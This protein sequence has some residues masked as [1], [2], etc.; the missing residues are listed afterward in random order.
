MVKGRGEDA[1]YELE[2]VHEFVCAIGGA[3]LIEKILVVVESEDT[4]VDFDYG[5]GF[6]HVPS[7]IGHM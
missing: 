5:Y 2:N 1:A 6:A 7:R 4:A 3:K